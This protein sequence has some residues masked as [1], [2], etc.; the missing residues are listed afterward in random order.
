MPVC[1]LF[2]SL[3]SFD[4]LDVLVFLLSDRGLIKLITQRVSNYFKRITIDSNKTDK[5]VALRKKKKGQNKIIITM[6][7]I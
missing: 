4:Q 1:V 2:L 6:L 7:K 3:Y 5:L